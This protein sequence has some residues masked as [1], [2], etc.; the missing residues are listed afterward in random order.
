MALFNSYNAQTTAHVGYIIGLVVAISAILYQ[1]DFPHFFTKYDKWYNRGI[2]YASLALLTG[3]IVFV[4]F[5]LLFWAPMS[6]MVLRVP[7]SD[8]NLL[9]AKHAGDPTYTPIWAIQAYCVTNFLSSNSYQ[10]FVYTMYQISVT[11]SGLLI[12]LFSSPLFLIFFVIDFLHNKTYAKLISQ[13]KGMKLFLTG[14]IIAMLGI[15]L[16]FS[17]DYLKLLE[18]ATYG[19]LFAIISFLGIFLMLIGNQIIQKAKNKQIIEKETLEKKL[20]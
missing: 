13:K 3:A 20:S 9:L 2:L 16:Y 1:V 18:T 11:E 7:L 6:D 12:L 19:V 8:V 15:S 5:R 10:S 17:R 14:S 4:G